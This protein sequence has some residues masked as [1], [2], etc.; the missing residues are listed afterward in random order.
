MMKLEILYEDDDVIVIH[1]PAGVASESARSTSP[2]VVSMVRNHLITQARKE[3]EKLDGPPFVGLVHRLDQPVE[4]ILVL[5]K[6]SKA[7]AIL[8]KELSDHAFTKKYYAL[9]E[10]ASFMEGAIASDS[11]LDSMKEKMVVLEDYLEKDNKTRLAKIVPKGQGKKARLTCI[12]IREDNYVCGGEDAVAK[13]DA[14]CIDDKNLLDIALETGRFHQI[15]IQLS[16]RGAAI[17]GDVKYGA[18]PDDRFKRGQIAL[19]A[20]EL[21]FTHPKT[22]ERMSFHIQ[23]QWACKAIKKT[24]KS[25]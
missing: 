12:K 16:S 2:D 14:C 24:E 10:D 9:V 7:T 18:K 17:V 3:G 15:R 23:P 13:K 21:S 11:G 19:C 8:S 6:N 1:K 22:K 25:K 5:G 4:G 20:Y